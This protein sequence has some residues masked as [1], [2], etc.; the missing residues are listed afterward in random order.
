MRVLIDLA[1][2]ADTA[3]GWASGPALKAAGGWR[4]SADADPVAMPKGGARKRGRA[5]VGIP[6]A[7]IAATGPPAV[8]GFLGW[9]ARESKAGGK[10][11]RR[12]GA[13]R[14]TAGDCASKPAS[15]GI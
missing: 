15:C 7:P 6:V 11:A 13:L 4:W 3:A 2:D 9:L 14:P 10:T 1:D 12:S 8:S 5:E